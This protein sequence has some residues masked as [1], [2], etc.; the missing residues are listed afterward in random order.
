[1]TALRNAWNRF[2]F[3]PEGPSNLGLC[4]AIFY[5]L[6]LLLYL[7]DDV[8]SWSTVSDAFWFPITLFKWA[9][10]P[11]LG[12]G[13]LFALDVVWKLALLACA[14][15]LAT[16]PA[17]LVAFAL[18]LYRLGLPHNYGKVHHFDAMIVLALGVLAFA[19]IGDAW[20]L[21]RRLARRRAPIA[22]SGEYRWPVRAVWV[23]LALTFFSA[24]VSKLRHGGIAWVTSE[25]MSILLNQHAYQVAAEDPL[26]A[27][28]GLYL[29]R[30]PA[31]CSLLALTT[32]IAE[33]GYPLALFFPRAR[34]I[35]PPAMC[36]ALI[37]IR[38]LMG[39]TFPQF[40]LCHL[41]WIPW[42]RVLARLVP[43]GAAVA[44]PPVADAS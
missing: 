43:A 41:F 26:L 44:P 18:G 3:A 32:V 36:A 30:Y 21:D 27:D 7:F 25:H 20:S 31:I 28:L 2:W 39:P 42:D 24:G 35:F 33:A 17:S 15:G 5:G 8:S 38:L 29:S 40:L 9:H 37:G 13:P 11:V 22:A 1:V 12:T 23:I 4:R 6:L 19:R 14:V 10:L 16:R 34:W